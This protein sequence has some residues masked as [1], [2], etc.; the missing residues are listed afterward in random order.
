MTPAVIVLAKAPA[1]GRSKTR[2]CPPLAPAEAAEL[3]AAA[4][5][6]TLEAAGK[7][8]DARVLLVLEGPAGPWLP[9]GFRGEIVRQRA[10]GLGDRLAGAFVTARGPALAVGMDTPQLTAEL[11]DRGLQTLAS[12]GV[13]A[14][15][16]P[17]ADGGYWAIGLR[18]ADAR[19]FAGVPMSTRRT[20]SA[21]RARLRK[22][23]LRVAELG[24]LQDV[25]TIEDAHEVAASVPGTRFAALLRSLPVAGR[26]AAEAGAG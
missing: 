7:V 11:L 1:A 22:L 14:V 15:L 25:D 18:R 10:G 24:R 20:G 16:G 26:A 9:S 17:S 21:Q 12:P 3:A 5:H 4:L 19:A 23:G 2:L 6:D 13:D 8:T